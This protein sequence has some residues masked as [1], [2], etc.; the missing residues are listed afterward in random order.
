[1]T[2]AALALE[3]PP[4]ALSAEAWLSRLEEHRKSFRPALAAYHRTEPLAAMPMAGWQT[5]A[6]A[7]ESRAAASR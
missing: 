4:G 6:K 1:M 5:A 7:V 3:R 2:R